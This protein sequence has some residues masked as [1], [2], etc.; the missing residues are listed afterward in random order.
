M[1]LP[2]LTIIIPVF[3]GQ[4]FLE[5][6]LQRIVAWRSRLGFWVDIIV[7]DD[8]ST[9]N[10]RKILDDF[11]MDKDFLKIIH[12]PRNTGKGYALRQGLEVAAG[13]FIG[14]TDSDLPY[15][16]DIFTEMLAE[17][18]TKN[19]ALVYGS[20]SH[21]NSAPLVDYGW[22]RKCGRKFFSFVVGSLIIKNI[23]DTQCGIKL[24]NAKLAKIVANK[25]VVN[26][27]AFDIELFMIALANKFLLQ[28]SPVVLNHRKE[29][30]IHVVKDTLRMLYDII[31]IKVNVFKK[32]YV[33]H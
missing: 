29:S 4:D 1:I 15:G 30:S 12:L 6:N 27:F 33:W 10:T 7:V 5:G 28:D 11:V 22:L 2:K 16:L 8:G 13:A 31:R 9:D 23:P 20:R 3:N 25:S 21:S 26:R 32:Y 14:F 24:I 18:E 17:A 19:I